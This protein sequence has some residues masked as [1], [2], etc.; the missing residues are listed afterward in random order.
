MFCAKSESVQFRNC[1][2]QSK[3]EVEILTLR[4][5]IPELLL[6]KVGIGRVRIFIFVRVF[7]IS[8]AY[9]SKSY[10]CKFLSHLKVLV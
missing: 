8:F 5:T 9:S 1:L 6:R 2:A 3:G 4:K 7:E 10:F